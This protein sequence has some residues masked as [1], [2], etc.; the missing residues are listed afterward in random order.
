MHAWRKCVLLKIWGAVTEI[1]YISNLTKR[2][3]VTWMK[4]CEALALFPFLQG[5]NSKNNE[6]P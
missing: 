4:F 6:I 3:D 2:L 5:V 1:P